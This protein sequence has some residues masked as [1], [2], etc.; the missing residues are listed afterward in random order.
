MLLSS[1]RFASLDSIAVFM[2]RGGH[3][4]TEI[5]PGTVDQNQPFTFTQDSIPLRWTPDTDRAD[6]SKACRNS[7][8][9]IVAYYPEGSKGVILQE[10]N[11]KKW[12]YVKMKNNIAVR[13]MCT[14]KYA[15]RRFGGRHFSTY[16]WIEKDNT[17]YNKTD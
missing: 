10:S 7:Q 3:M 1:D 5:L 16:G 6:Y 12:Y 8:T 4:G 2:G 11:D 14:E 9:N 13:N 17:S 15:K